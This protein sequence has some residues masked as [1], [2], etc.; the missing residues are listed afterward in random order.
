[1]KIFPLIIS[2]VDKTYFKGDV[3]SVTVPGSEGEL[4]ILKNH[5]ALV[6]VLK[7]GVITVR[8]KED[9]KTFQVD[10]GIVEVHR[11]GVIILV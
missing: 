9:T 8:E 11:D 7:Q 5:E 10:D 1:M 3:S 4:T 2:A 6:S